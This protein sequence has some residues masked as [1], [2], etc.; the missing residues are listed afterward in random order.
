M[1]DRRRVMST[2]PSHAPVR[3]RGLATGDVGAIVRLLRNGWFKRPAWDWQFEYP[4]QRADAPRPVVAEMG[5]QVVGFNGLMP[6]R[7]QTELGVLN[8]A[9]SC[10][11]VVDRPHRRS[12]VGRLLKKALDR[13]C[14]LIMAKGTSQAAAKVL[15]RCGWIE[16]VGPRQH[17]LFIRP[18]ELRGRL[19]AALQAT[20]RAFGVVREG[21]S[22]RSGQFEWRE[23]L[24]ASSEIDALWSAHGSGY[25]RT[26]VR[27]AEY[28]QWRYGAFPG[29]E[30]R[31]LTM[32]SGDEPQALLVVRRDGDGVRI[33]DY[34]GPAR[35]KPVKLALIRKLLETYPE[36]SRITTVTTDPEF[37]AAMERLGAWPT[38]GGSAGFFVRD[39]NG[40]LSDPSA[41]WFL[42]DG[43]SDGEILS[44][45]R[46]V[47]PGVTLSPV[48]EQEFS[49]I[50][51]DWEKIRASGDFDAL[52]MSWDWQWRWW[53]HFGRANDVDPRFLRAETGDGQVV[54][55]FPL[56]EWAAKAR[57][58][59]PTRRLQ[60]LGHLFQGPAAMRT[61]YLDLLVD[62]DWE[63][64]ACAALVAWL[65]NHRDWE[66]YLVQDA[67]AGSPA[68]RG[69]IA[70]LSSASYMRELTEPGV[71]ETRFVRTD[72][73]FEDYLASLGS[74][75]RRALY[76]GRKRLARLGEIS[77]RDAGPFEVDDGLELLN[78]LHA[79]RWGSPVFTGDRFVFHREL[80]ADAAERGKLRLSV[81]Q[82]DGEPVSVIYD[83]IAGRRRYNLQQGFS[84]DLEGFKGSLGLIHFG[85][86]IEES[87]RDPAVDSY[88]LLAGGGQHEL[89]KA[90]LG[91]EAARLRSVQ[92]VRGRLRRFLYRTYDLMHKGEER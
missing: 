75:T 30:Y 21:G 50:T 58:Y 8:A 6:I 20:A 73:E 34:V 59:W 80:A 15:P 54:G 48:S 57:R 88:D 4:G 49:Q 11:F 78:S 56:I 51:A 70:G 39:V 23:V 31:Y 36:A 40:S 81:I 12:G 65:K 53:H 89:Y 63:E 69:L 66:E 28:M 33:V 37:H 82:V 16:G 47:A 71:D 83:L 64:P 79:L 55:I 52:F 60:L 18:R 29:A 72:R 27:D 61:E 43:D 22:S 91:T 17:V 26:V 68:V 85:Y 5:G 67:P 41:G 62:P 32:R 10:D 24:P 92:L 9:W 74:S 19:L 14:P 7:V 42:M 46:E 45:A 13:E 44:M 2:E 77:V 86:A 84:P 35:G 25:R 1:G 87:C 38:R 3:C 76:H 90:R